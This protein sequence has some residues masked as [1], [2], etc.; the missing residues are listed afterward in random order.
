MVYNWLAYFPDISW[1][2]DIRNSQK[3][4]IAYTSYDT[5]SDHDWRINY[6]KYNLETL[7][8]NSQEEPQSS[9]YP[10]QVNSGWIRYK[11]QTRKPTLPTVTFCAPSTLSLKKVLIP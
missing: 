1:E 11:A 2:W 3:Q 7:K 10:T 5:N 4:K 6:S 8:S 9:S